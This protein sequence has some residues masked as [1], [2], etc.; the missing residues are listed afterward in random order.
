MSS[1]RLLELVRLPTLWPP[2]QILSSFGVNFQDT[3]R[4][5]G[6]DKLLNERNPDDC[7]THVMHRRFCSGLLRHYLPL[8]TLDTFW[9]RSRLQTGKCVNS[10][11]RRPGGEGR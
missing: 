10:N 8:L 6:Q 9:Y 5:Y 7:N 11:S 2:L 3:F 4:T 1:F